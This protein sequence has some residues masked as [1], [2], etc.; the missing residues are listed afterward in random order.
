MR[1][2][3]KPLPTAWTCSI[4]TDYMALTI[5]FKEVEFGV[6]DKIRVVQKIKDGDKTRES[7]FEG[8]V[9]KI[10]GR[11]PGKTFTLRKIAEGNVGVEKIY[12]MNLP[13]MDRI[14]V[15]KRGVEGVRR[16]KLYY[17]R[18]K[19]PT[20]V[21]MIYKRSAT[22]LAHGKKTSKRVSIKSAVQKKDK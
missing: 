1:L 2:W 19:S 18:T 11:N 21:E 7:S 5:A 4:I 20:E 9:I 14:I 10:K 16:A 12:P 22:R 6:G 8:M 3:L 15:V 13:S 17:T